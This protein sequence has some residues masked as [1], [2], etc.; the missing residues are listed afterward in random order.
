MPRSG[1]W[2]SRCRQ[3]GEEP[4]HTEEEGLEGVGCRRPASIAF[5]PVMPVW[6][7]GE[8]AFAGSK[9]G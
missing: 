8:I 4:E 5:V 9:T 3:A 2:R 6:V 1:R 7:S